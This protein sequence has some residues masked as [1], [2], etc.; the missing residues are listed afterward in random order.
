LNSYLEAE[1][2]RET[3]RAPLDSKPWKKL[4]KR[5]AIDLIEA[6]LIRL[7]W[8]DQHDRERAT[9]HVDRLRF[10]QLVGRVGAARPVTLLE[11]GHSARCPC[12]ER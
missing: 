1:A 3:T 6:I 11:R 5:Q 9:A 2:Q 7:T 4:P 10:V 12:D 8:L